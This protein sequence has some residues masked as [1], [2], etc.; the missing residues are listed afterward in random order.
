MPSFIGRITRN[1][2]Q[3]FGVGS[4]YR[5][6][7]VWVQNKFLGFGLCQ[8]AVLGPLQLENNNQ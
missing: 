3:Q 5:L 2:G 8:C 7:K 1:M 6:Y 4:S